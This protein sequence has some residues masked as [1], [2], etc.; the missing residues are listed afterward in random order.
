MPFPSYD[1]KGGKENIKKEKKTW[2]K[3]ANILNADFAFVAV[4]SFAGFFVLES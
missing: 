4:G 3:D 2:R 1:K